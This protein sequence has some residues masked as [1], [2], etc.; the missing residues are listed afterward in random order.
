MPLVVF[1]S[2][3][4]SREEQVEIHAKLPVSHEFGDRSAE[5]VDGTVL[6]GR[7]EH[8]AYVSQQLR[9]KT[10][11]RCTLINV[12][13]THTGF[14]LTRGPLEQSLGVLTCFLT[15]ADWHASGLDAETFFLQPV[16]SI[17]PRVGQYS[18][19]FTGYMASMYEDIVMALQ[20]IRLSLGQKKAH[21]KV[22]PLGV[23]PSIKSRYGDSL[24]PLVMPA[25][26]MALQYACNEVLHESWV[27]AVEFV[28]HSRNLSPFLSLDRVRI[29]SNSRRD[30][31]DF[32]DISA[33]TVPVLLVP[34]DPF[35]RI[36]GKANDKNLAATL[37][38]NSNL[39]SQLDALDFMPWK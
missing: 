30:A 33:G 16:Q 38:N 11:K 35:C 19:N 9:M 7:A 10:K 28:D 13:A 15:V 1:N 29:Y 32:K 36:G 27:D 26:L 34:C 18:F 25:Y 8:D 22:V 17:C 24:A 3:W 20:S 23:G 12:L 5:L 31:F 4:S 21:L 14:G 6:K 2:S 39:R 37:A